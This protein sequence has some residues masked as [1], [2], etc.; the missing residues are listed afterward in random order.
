M[1]SQV[2]TQQASVATSGEGEGLMSAVVKG[3]LKEQMERGGGIWRWKEG[4]GY[5]DG[6]ASQAAVADVI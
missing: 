1:I 3:A 4:G 6:G 5:M 2:V